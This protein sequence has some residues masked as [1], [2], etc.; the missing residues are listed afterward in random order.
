MGVSAWEDG[1]DG[2]DVVGFCAEWKRIYESGG[3]SVEKG[4]EDG[5]GEESDTE[6]GVWSD[7]AEF[8]VSAKE[9]GLCVCGIFERS[10]EDAF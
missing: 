3:G 10:D 2:E 8:W 4:G 1:E 6:K 5:G 7:S 9:D